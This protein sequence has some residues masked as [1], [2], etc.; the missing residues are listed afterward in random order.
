MAAFVP[1]VSPAATSCPTV[2]IELN[3]LVILPEI[4]SQACPSILPGTS[5]SQPIS[6]LLLN[7]PTIS[8]TAL[9]LPLSQSSAPVTVPHSLTYHGGS[10]G[11]P[12]PG[13]ASV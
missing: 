11:A 12:P 10:A 13:P 5:L 7:R 6:G 2:T 9:I 8:L 3:K 4:E 1:A